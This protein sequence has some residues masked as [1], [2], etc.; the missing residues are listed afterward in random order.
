MTKA[1]A[2]GPEAPTAITALHERRR[3][4][5][6]GML[7][8]FHGGDIAAPNG[9]ATLVRAP[10]SSLLTSRMSTELWHLALPGLLPTE[11]DEPDID[12]GSCEARQYDCLGSQGPRLRASAIPNAG[13][14]H[15]ARAPPPREWSGDTLREGPAGARS[16]RASVRPWGCR[17]GHEWNAGQRPPGRRSLLSLRSGEHP[18]AAMKTLMAAP[19]LL[20]VH[21]HALRPPTGHMG[22]ECTQLRNMLLAFASRLP[23]ALSAVVLCHRPCHEIAALCAGCQSH[24]QADDVAWPVNGAEKSTQL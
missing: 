14:L 12:E 18:F 23:A 9:R 6:L 11:A 21:G 3:G 22:C 2:C 10:H 17:L 15:G 24:C 4:R 13:R 16:S 8:A 7:S 19:E 20:P 5:S 1:T